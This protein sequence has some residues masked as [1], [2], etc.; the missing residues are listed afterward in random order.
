MLQGIWFQI[1]FSLLTK[2]DS[3]LGSQQGFVTILLVLTPFTSGKKML[4]ISN[5]SFKTKVAYLFLT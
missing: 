3:V 2:F 1:K 4:S 5:G